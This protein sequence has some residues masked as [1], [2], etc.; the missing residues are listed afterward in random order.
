MPKSPVSA[1]L[2]KYSNRGMLTNERMAWK[3]G[4][5]FQGCLSIYL[6]EYSPAYFTRIKLRRLRGPQFFIEKKEDFP[7]LGHVVIPTVTG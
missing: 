7:L 5:S 4:T 6:Y 3:R 1:R 2:Y